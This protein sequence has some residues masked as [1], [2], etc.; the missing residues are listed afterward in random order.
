MDFVQGNETA[1]RIIF[2]DFCINHVLVECDYGQILQDE[3]SLLFHH[4]FYL[5][6]VIKRL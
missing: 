5:F 4:A 6:L 1:F 2:G 3:A